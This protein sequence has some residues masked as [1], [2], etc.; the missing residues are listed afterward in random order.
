MLGRGSVRNTLITRS[1]LLELPWF[2]QV[3]SGSRCRSGSSRPSV[4]PTLCL[5]AAARVALRQLCLRRGDWVS[6]SHVKAHANPTGELPA[7]K[8]GLPEKAR[9]P[10]AKKETG[11]YPMPKQGHTISAKRSLARIARRATSRRT[12]SSASNARPTGHR[13]TADRPRCAEGHSG[14][15]ARTR[16]S[17]PSSRA[18]I[19]KPRSGSRSSLE[20]NRVS[21]AGP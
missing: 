21:Q 11:N 16:P 18:A 10:E 20:E 4:T 3:R 8:F 2:S 19:S 7:R 1:R 15:Y 12:S 9:S 13:Q 5:C 6:T 14:S 17:R